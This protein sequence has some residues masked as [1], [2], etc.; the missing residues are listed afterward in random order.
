M[1]P[2]AA[3]SVPVHPSWTGIIE[4]LVW[5]LGGAVRWKGGSV[6]L[7]LPDHPHPDRVADLDALRLCLGQIGLPVVFDDSRVISPDASLVEFLD[8]LVGSGLMEASD[9]LAA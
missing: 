3:M 8:L 5:G 6:V 4:V 7:Q 9:H 1:S 2:V